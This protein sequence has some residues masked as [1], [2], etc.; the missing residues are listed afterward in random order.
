[1]TQVPQISHDDVMDILEMTSKLESCMNDILREIRMDLALSAL[2]SASINCIIFQCSTL[3]EIENYR[4]IFMKIFDVSI[5]T[6]QMEEPD[7][8]PS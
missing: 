3:S 5:K 4:N 8:A 2:M 7:Q 6:I 1:M